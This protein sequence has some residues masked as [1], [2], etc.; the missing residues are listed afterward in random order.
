MPSAE[1]LAARPDARPGPASRTGARAAAAV[2]AVTAGH[3]ALRL[4]VISNRP[5]PKVTDEIGYLINARVLA[6]GPPGDLSCCTVYSGGY[7]LLLAPLAALWPDPEALYRGALLLGVVLTAAVCPVLYALART[8]WSASH[9]DALAA[10]AGGAAVPSLVIHT[11]LAWTEAL[12]PLLIASW[13]LAVSLAAAPERDPRGRA[14]ALVVAGVLAAWLFTTHTRTAP[15][16]LVH[17]GI[18]VW[19]A[20]RRTMRGRDLLVGAA[21]LATGLLA[22]HLLNA[23]LAAVNWPSRP[24]T[25][26]F[27]ANVAPNLADL[28]ALARVGVLATGSLWTLSTATGA[29]AVV[30]ALGMIAQLRPGSGR[31]ARVVAASVLAGTMGLAML[32]ALVVGPV[33]TDPSYWVYGR[34][35]EPIAPVLVTAGLLLLA[36]IGRLVRAARSRRHRRGV[37][38]LGGLITAAAGVSAAAVAVV[39]LYVGPALLAPSTRP[40]AVVGLAGPARSVS[41]LHPISATLVAAGVLTLAALATT[42]PRGPELSASVA[43]AA[44]LAS[45]ATFHGLWLGPHDALFYPGRRTLA[46]VAELHNAEVIAWCEPKVGAY[47]PYTFG[48]FYAPQAR[49]ERFPVAGKPA[50]DAD[51]VIG[52][53]G[54]APELGWVRT[55]SSP[56]GDLE[57]WVPIRGAPPPGAGA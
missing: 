45:I 50:P 20:T 26:P 32:A 37:L 17:L 7:S 24:D 1:V 13:L 5:G 51:V 30:G 29:L 19:W 55:A 18:L 25:D 53:A 9:R 44:A 23:H 14:T 43:A 57:L 27:L 34:Y 36:R 41:A 3:V 6:G 11:G 38:A 22:G 15:L 48:Q 33:L 49:I 39:L 46:D 54:C 4:V 16:V 28:G 52:P 8:A 2:A 47:G 10:S 40:L 56:D 35:V 21:T 42:L 12:L 31:P